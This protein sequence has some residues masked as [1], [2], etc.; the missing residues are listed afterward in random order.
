MIPFLRGRTS[1]GV[2]YPRGA[3]QNFAARFRHNAPLQ[4]VQGPSELSFFFL[5]GVAEACGAELS[6]AESSGSSSV[7]TLPRPS[8]V[9]ERSSTERTVHPEARPPSRTPE[10]VWDVSS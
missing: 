6:S 5:G 3:P 4:V 10:A 2:V 9:A 8:D 7:T 1:L